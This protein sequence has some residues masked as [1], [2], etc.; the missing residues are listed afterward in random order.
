[1]VA[2]EK[3]PD[4]KKYGGYAAIYEATTPIFNAEIGERMKYMRMKMK[5]DQK[6]LGAKLGVSQQTISSLETGKIR[7]PEKPFTTHQFLEV[8]GKLASHVLYGTND[9][10]YGHITREYWDARLKINRKPGSGAWKKGNNQGVEA[11]QETR[12]KGKRDDNT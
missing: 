2:E 1:M 5:M 6:E 12:A 11:Q 8:F 7:V 10:P 4:T 9:F 3:K